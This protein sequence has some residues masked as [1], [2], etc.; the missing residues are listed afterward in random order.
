M[1]K[2]NREA[3]DMPIG[4]LM[5]LAMNRDAMSTFSRLGDEQQTSVIHF[6]EDAITGED[7]KHRISEVVDRLKNG[8][9]GPFL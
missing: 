3:Q 7:A 5:S 2:E 1:S 6:V 4:L 9:T 8:D